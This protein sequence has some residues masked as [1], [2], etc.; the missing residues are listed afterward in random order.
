MAK[1]ASFGVLAAVAFATAIG[2]TYAAN[3]LLT[4]SLDES[5]KAL[6]ATMTPESKCQ[7]LV[8][9]MRTNNE[10]VIRWGSVLIEMSLMSGSNIFRN[11]FGQTEV[12][13]L[14]RRSFSGCAE[15]PG[16]TISS[17][18]RASFQSITDEIHRPGYRDGPELDDVSLPANVQTAAEKLRSMLPDAPVVSEARITMKAK[19]GSKPGGE[20]TLT[21]KPHKGGTT[22]VREDYRN[23]TMDREL[24][25]LVQLK[26]RNNARGYT[27]PSGDQR[28]TT[29][30]AIA[31]EASTWTA[32]GS[33][34]F[35]I[36]T[37]A[38]GG[39]LRTS[40]KIGQQVDASVVHSSFTGRA[41][42]LACES[43]DSKS[44]GYYIEE[45]RYYLRMHSESKYGIAD[46]RIEHLDI[47][48]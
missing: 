37:S 47:T 18:A 28:I 13:E 17:Q 23:F 45:L 44:Q 48:R 29:T 46:D 31:L 5:T 43:S 1:L 34:S 9:A 6:L 35:E 21:I 11:E 27:E 3:R 36:D 42:P 7:V 2:N 25:G 38:R 8:D 20:T 4:E 24:M 16:D 32:G 26:S 19:D 40:C 12:K 22:H 10:A 39:A 15:H 14:H 30:T 41:W 33:F